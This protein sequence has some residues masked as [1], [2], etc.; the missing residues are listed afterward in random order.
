MKTYYATVAG[1]INGAYREKGAP[2][3]RMTQQG[4]KYLVLGG[5]VSDKKPLPPV[6]LVDD[7]H[8]TAKKADTT[9]GAAERK[10]R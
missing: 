6:P 8:E 2:C 9:S 7:Q 10:G 3:G 5:L 1:Y 4:A